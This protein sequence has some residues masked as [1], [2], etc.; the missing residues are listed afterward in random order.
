MSESQP[1]TEAQLRYYD[2]LKR[3]KGRRGL[4][5]ELLLDGRWHPNH[6][7][8]A[9]GGL[10]FNDSIFTFRK[11]GWVIESRHVRGGIWEFRLA[12]KA[13]PPQGHKPMS[14]PQRLVAG[15]YMHV[16]SQQLGLSASLKVR[17]AVPEW[18]HCDPKE[19]TSTS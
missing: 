11:E 5:L 7:C 9:V 6:E 16:I 13:D 1:L 19:A 2:D 4:L 12:G 3:L 18:M 10:S 15:H 8:A 14:R 17:R